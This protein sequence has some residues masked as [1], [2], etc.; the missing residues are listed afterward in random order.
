MTKVLKAIAFGAVLGIAAT[1]VPHITAATFAGV[2]E[3]DHHDANN[4]HADYSNNRFYKLGNNEGY[5]DYQHKTQRPPHNHN[6]RNDE[7]RKAHDYGYQQGL[8]GQHANHAD[9][10]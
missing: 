3:Q 1:A 8:Q 7:D 2:Q 6:Y 4:Q 10:H 5:K 9:P